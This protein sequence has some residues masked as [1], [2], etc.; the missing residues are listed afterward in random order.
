MFNCQITRQNIEKE[1]EKAY[2]FDLGSGG[3][4]W[5]PKSQVTIE[6]APELPH[7]KAG[8]LTIPMWLAK[9]KG[10]FGMQNWWRS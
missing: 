5:M 9:Q 2:G 3:I 4:V 6:W 1:T 8:T 7:I 10:M